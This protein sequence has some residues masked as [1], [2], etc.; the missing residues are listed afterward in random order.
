MFKD[1][2]TYNSVSCLYYLLGMYRFH[3]SRSQKNRVAYEARINA[4]AESWQGVILDEVRML[5][6]LSVYLKSEL[7]YNSIDYSRQ[8][9]ESFIKHEIV[10]AYNAM[11][12]NHNRMVTVVDFPQNKGHMNKRQG[13]LHYYD[14]NRCLFC[15]TFET[16]TSRDGRGVGENLLV[17]PKYLHVSK[18]WISKS[19]GYHQNHLLSEHYRSSTNNKQEF[20]VTIAQHD[21]PHRSHE[22]ILN[23]D[24]CMKIEKFLSK[25]KTFNDAYTYVC[26]LRTS[27]TVS[28]TI[29]KQNQE[30]DDAMF[31]EEVGEVDCKS[32]HENPESFVRISQDQEDISSEDSSRQIQENQLSSHVRREIDK[33]NTAMFRMPF[34]T[35]DDNLP[36]LAGLEMESRVNEGHIYERFRYDRQTMFK[37]DQIT[38]LNGR[39]L[40]DAIINFWLKW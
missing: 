40:N 3:P 28:D 34:R 1:I 31:F 39:E 21:D 24:W 8:D 35:K 15:V 20:K 11:F 4:R 17:S 33:L 36:L 9:Q 19:R 30:Q 16:K 22:I 2:L 26:L 27:K 32:S 29:R 7:K 12:R 10:K 13:I 18:P 23:R 14:T 38:L 37:R 5:S 25:D 6:V